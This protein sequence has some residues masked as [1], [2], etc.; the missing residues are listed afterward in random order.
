MRT[1]LPNEK[2]SGRHTCDGGRY[3]YPPS[4]PGDFQSYSGE[5]YRYLALTTKVDGQWAPSEQIGPLLKSTQ[6]ETAQFLRSIK[7]RVIYIS[8]ICG[9]CVT[10]PKNSGAFFST[11]IRDSAPRCLLSRPIILLIAWGGIM[12]EVRKSE[13]MRPYTSKSQE[14]TQ[15][16]YADD[17]P[18]ACRG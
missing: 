7:A 1:V 17:P 9:R 2:S 5:R 14:K 13:E 11:A 12:E 8:D 15:A 18:Y 3:H 10:G 4:T 16:N 6:M